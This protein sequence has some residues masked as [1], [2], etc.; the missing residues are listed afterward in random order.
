M[1]SLKQNPSQTY[2]SLLKAVRYVSS[3]ADR[4]TVPLLM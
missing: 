2:Q 4:S 3:V 1:L